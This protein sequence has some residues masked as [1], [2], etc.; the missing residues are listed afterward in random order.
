MAERPGRRSRLWFRLALA[1][2]LGLGLGIAVLLSSAASGGNLR[3]ELCAGVG[4][5][6]AVLIQLVRETAADPQPPAEAVE[7]PLW[8]GGDYFAKLRQLERRL[9]AASRD[10]SKYDRNVR[11]VLARLATERL[12]QKYGI[13]P[14]RHPVQ[15]REVLGEQLWS[16]TIAPPGPA[17]PAPSHAELSTLVTLIEA[18]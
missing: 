18:L 15:A 3:P 8:P 9:E 12:R 2:A 5:A 4:V 7:P 16:L 10:G 6:V 14:R 1:A 13:D 11:P 17:S